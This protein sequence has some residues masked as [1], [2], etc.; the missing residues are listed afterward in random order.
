MPSA[1]E[2]SGFVRE[3]FDTSAR[4]KQAAGSALADD[5]VRAAQ[6]IAETYA[7]GGTVYTFGNG[8]SASD[9]QHLVGELLGRYHRNRRPLAAVALSTDP[10]TLTC[11]ANDFSYDEIFSR[12]VEG[13]ARPQDV[14]VGFTT[15]G[16]SPNVIKGL[17]AARAAGARTIAFTREG[18]EV[19]EV[20][21]VAIKV[22]ASYTPRIQECHLTSLHALC[23]LIE[24]LVVDLPLREQQS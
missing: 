1:S 15:S 14:V 23:E 22:P 20:V 18:G 21:D 24:L 11:I 3:V 13:L 19:V 17:Q 9:A 4:I 5:I 2:L 7:K 12:Q 6:T 10:S 8:G 16:R